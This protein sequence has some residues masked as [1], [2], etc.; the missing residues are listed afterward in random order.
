[1]CYSV[2]RGSDH[3]LTALIME[4]ICSFETLVCWLSDLHGIT[5]WNAEI[6]VVHAMTTLSLSVRYL[7]FKRKK[8]CASFWVVSR[9]QNFVRRRF[10]TVCSV[11]MGRYPPSKMEQGVPKR[12]HIKFWHRGIT[13][14]KAYNVRYMAKVWNREEKGCPAACYSG[15]ADVRILN[16]VTSCCCCV[17]F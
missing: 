9:C 1:M 14:K 16:V 2:V 3:A 5:A 6:F 10:I 12:R 11:S 13:Q 7:Q 15:L 17:F 8:S 4:V